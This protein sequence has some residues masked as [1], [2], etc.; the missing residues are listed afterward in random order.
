MM[1][2]AMER[3]CKMWPAANMH[4]LTSHPDLLPRYSPRV[5]PLANTGRLRWLSEN[6][7][8]SSFGVRQNELLRARSRALSLHHPSTAGFLRR[9]RY[10]SRYSPQDH[11]A[12]DQFLAL[13]RKADLFVVAGMGGLT[14]AFPEYAVM[15]LDT[16]TLARACNVPTVLFG[17]RLGPFDQ[18]LE[19]HASRVLRQV[20]YIAC[21]K[22]NMAPRSFAR[23]AY[24][25][26]SGRSPEMMRLNWRSSIVVSDLAGRLVLTFG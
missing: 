18:R 22:A 6:L 16:L 19:K 8:S 7:I 24:R 14:S 26:R 13:M 9:L 3:L 25:R 21:A 2:I 4:V 23:G 17:Q 20:D 15:V 1:Q 10:R 5:S 11:R 12:I